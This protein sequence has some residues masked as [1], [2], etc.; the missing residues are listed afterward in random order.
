MW[1]LKLLESHSMMYTVIDVETTGKTNKITEISLFRYKSGEL[2]DEFTSL[3]NPLAFIPDYI[4][5]LTGIDNSMVADAPTFPE[6]SDRILEI[7]QDAVFIA[8]N[9]NF[10]YN[11]IR[12]EFKAINIAFNRRKVCTVRLSRTLLPGH[13][14]YS[15]GKLCASLQIPIYDRHRAKGDVEATVLLFHKLLQQPNSAIVLESALSKSSKEATLPS[16]LPAETFQNLPKQPGI[17]FFR[18]RKNKIIYVGKAKD[19]QKRVLGHFYA[20]TEKELNM[21]RE[22]AHVD[23]ELS[24]TEIIALLMEDSAIKHHFPQFNQAA[25]RVVKTFAVFTYT[26]RKG[27]AHLAYNETKATPNPLTIMYSITECRA[28]IQQLQHKFQL[29]SKYCHLADICDGKDSFLQACSGICQNLEEIDAYNNRVFEAIKYITS[30]ASS[31]IIKQKGRFDHEDAFILIDNGAYQGY[32]FIDKSEQISHITE[33]E[34]F[35]IRQK[36]NPD[37]RRILRKEIEK[38]TIF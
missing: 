35:L 31:M 18:N 37:I 29:C 5:A 7:T 36:D 32:G 28:F 27:I 17:Y 25:K 9:V 26:D 2:L 1:T 3:V 23:Y 10:D 22:T 6:I 13:K 34:P 30:S 33:F 4:T 38:Y 19:I 24:G 21:C 14:S 12:N 16:H 11:V 15:L 8:H 20:K